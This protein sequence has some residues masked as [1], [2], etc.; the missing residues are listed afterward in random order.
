MRALEWP[1]LLDIQHRSDTRSTIV[2]NPPSLLPYL[3]IR[4]W[5]LTRPS[6]TRSVIVGLKAHVIAPSVA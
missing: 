3:E 4:R 6:S 1:D 2:T 5:E